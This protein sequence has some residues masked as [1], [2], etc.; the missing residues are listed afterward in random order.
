MIMMPGVIQA[1]A[2]EDERHFM[3]KLYTDYHLLM[4]ST[5]WKQIKNREDAEDIVSDSCV[6]L[7]AKI[8][9]L[10]KMSPGALRHYITLTVRNTAIDFLRRQRLQNTSM[11][12]LDDTVE[13]LPNPISMEE[14]MLLSEHMHTVLRAIH[15]LPEHEQDALR[16]KF[17]K[18]KTDSEIA[19]MLGLSENSVRAYISRARRHLNAALFK[20]EEND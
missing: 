7:L 10:R 11:Q 15:Q 17:Q 12:Q 3:E 1:I 18:N 6:S 16:L 19:A 20:E 2:D 14:K 5:A 4:L 9:T 13:Q 8:E